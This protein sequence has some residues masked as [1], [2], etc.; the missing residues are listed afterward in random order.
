MYVINDTSLAIQRER[1]EEFF[2]D[3]HPLS[4]IILHAQAI[5]NTFAIAFI[6]QALF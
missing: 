3:L 2:E 4:H 6:Y 1:M 5:F